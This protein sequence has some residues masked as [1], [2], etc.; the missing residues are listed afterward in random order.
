MPDEARPAPLTPAAADDDAP[1]TSLA[2][3]VVARRARQ[4]GLPLP[5]RGDTLARWRALAEIARDDVCVAKVLEAHYDAQAI[6]ADL[7]GQAAAAD[8]GPGEL[9]AVWAAEPPDARVTFVATGESGTGVLEGTKVWCSGSDLVDAAL[10]TAHEDGQRVLVHVDM[11]AAGIERNDA[12]WQAVGMARVRSGRVRFDRTP[13]RRIGGPGA[14][15]ERPGFWHGGAGIAACWFGAAA[16]IADVLRTD[17]RAGRSPHEQAHLGA[18]DMALSAT[19]SLLRETAGLIDARP[20][21]PHVRAVTRVRSHAERVAT[22]V[23]DRVGRALG[24]GPLCSDAAHARRCADLTTF[25]RQSHAEHDWA[26]LGAAVQAD[27]QAWTL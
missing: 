19:A 15:L 12:D 4:A 11:T 3:A 20:D 14:Y 26:A 10:V 16:G 23:I 8:A 25:I 24:P 13:A 6:L 2:A 1:T 18:I 22:E 7:D 21:Q 17:A 5:G 27:G 9:L